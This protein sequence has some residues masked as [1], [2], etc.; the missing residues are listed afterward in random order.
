MKYTL[1]IFICLVISM[2]TMAQL[3]YCTFVSHFDETPL[4]EA[5]IRLEKWCKISIE[6]NTEDLKG[7]YV[8]ERIDGISIKKA[9]DLILNGTSLGYEV[10]NGTLI[11]LAPKNSLVKY[12]RITNEFKNKPLDKMFFMWSFNHKLEIDYDENEIKDIKIHGKLV[13]EPLD[14]AFSKILANTPLD[15][16]IISERHIRVYL[17]ESTKR[18]RSG[19]KISKN[20]TVSGVLKDEHTGESLP[21]AT[22]LISGT[23]KGTTTNVDGRFTLFDVP[24]DTSQLDISYIGYR[25]KTILLYPSMDM[26][27]LLLTLQ[28][29]SLQIEEIT[30]AAVRKEQLIRASAGISKIGM[31]PEVAAILPSY[32]EKDIFRSL[33]LLPGVSGTNESSSGL[34]VRGG[35]PDQ[36][37]ILFD[38]FTVYHVDHLF[39]FFSAFNSNAIKDL[40]LYKG[41]YEAKFG[42]RL[43]SVVDMT[44][45]DG[46]SESFNMG[47]GASL[48]SVNGFVESPF[49]N[50]KGSFILAGRRS[51]PKWFLFKPF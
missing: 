8:T 42:G 5:I 46:N 35:T 17:P 18:F 47:I 10:K 30:I 12:V 40:Q 43:S 13:D 44:G 31:T 26:D 41:G 27:N 32:G 38:G 48:L 15:Y 19:Q 2:T 45:K 24:T 34:F 3:S 4:E 51:F 22:I 25:S 1:T 11:Q 23:N 7:L 21:F 14:L 29:G 28:S 50:G 20:I 6:Y 37:L 36:N 9:L 33:Q 39:G 16:E 49:V